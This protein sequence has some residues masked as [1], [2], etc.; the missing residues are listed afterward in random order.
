MG[1]LG[2]LG[3]VIIGEM[4][5]PKNRGVLLTFISLS[6]TIG[7]LFTHTVGSILSWQTTALFCSGITFTSLLMIIYS[8]ESPPWLSSKG[9][10]EE[11]REVFLWLRGHTRDQEDELEKMIAAKMMERKSSV[12]G[13]K[14]SFAHKI[15]RTS[16]F[17][18]ETY[19]R[20]DFY[21]PIII[22]VHMYTMFQFAGSNVF[23][24]YMMDILKQVV[25]PDVNAKFW[26]VF[27]DIERLISNLLAVS[28]MAKL[29]RRTLLFSSGALCVLSYLGK[30]GYVY[31]KQ[32]DMLP[33]ENQWIPICLLGV[34]MF[35]LTVG[36]S[37][38]PFTVSGE[39]FPLAYRGI[40]GG[41][42]VL[43]LS[44]NFFVAV[45]SFPVLGGLVGLPLTYVIYAGV[46]TYCL[47]VVFFMLPETKDRT[48]QE[49][50][51]SFRGGRTSNVADE[52]EAASEPLKN[53]DVKY[54]MGR[55][56]SS[57]IIL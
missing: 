48:L 28:L 46:V 11:C 4:T 25:G 53:S 36:V 38:I 27:F 12:A 37:S 3:S 2:P 23:S 40:A 15:R 17:I 1:M 26:M 8:P 10:F 22:M 18:R 39:I 16:R 55:R 31:A 6:L 57:T 14:I 51:E 5:D 47:T 24:S 42:S 35:S 32:N 43:A 52:D 49:I 30:A 29:K 41:L 21:K 13:Q 20:P 44:A 33:F 19:K 45:K 54:S 7:V 34:Y 50:E 56:C 9:R